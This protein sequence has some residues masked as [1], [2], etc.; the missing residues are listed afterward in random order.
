[1]FL[2]PSLPS[3]EAREILAAEFHPPARR[4]DI[5]AYDDLRPNQRNW[6]LGRIL[7][8]GFCASSEVVPGERI[9]RQAEKELALLARMW[10]ALSTRAFLLD[11]ARHHKISLPEE[12]LRIAIERWGEDHDITPASTWLQANG[13]TAQSCR[14]LLAEKFLIA[15]LIAQGLRFAGRKGHC[16]SSAV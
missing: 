14:S 16:A 1:V 5:F 7:L 10:N 3:H 12:W 13:L 11:W 4:G 9:L 8:T 6:Q 2:G 15:W